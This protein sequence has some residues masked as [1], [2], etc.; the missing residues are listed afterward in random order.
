MKKVLLIF[1][2]SP[3]VVIAL[4]LITPKPKRSNGANEQE[5]K[6]LERFKEQQREEVQGISDFEKLEKKSSEKDNKDD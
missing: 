1:V 4:N 3:V 5:L 2:L 6:M